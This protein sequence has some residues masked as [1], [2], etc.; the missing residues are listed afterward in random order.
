[1]EK[2]EENKSNIKLYRYFSQDIS[3]IPCFNPFRFT[4]A[5]YLN[6]KDEGSHLDF[7]SFEAL[8][9]THNSNVLLKGYNAGKRIWDNENNKRE[10]QE[11]YN[12]EIK[13]P[14]IYR[15]WNL[16]AYILSL[17]P[18]SPFT[19]N[20]VLWKRY[21][22]LKDVKDIIQKGHDRVLEYEIKIPKGCGFLILPFTFSYNTISIFDSVTY[23]SK[24][25]MS[26][27]YANINSIVPI[28]PIDAKTRLR[29]LV[30][31]GYLFKSSYWVAEREFRIVTLCPHLNIF[32]KEILTIEQKF[33]H[34]FY[35]SPLHKYCDNLY[36]K[37]RPMYRFFFDWCIQNNYYSNDITILQRDSK[38][39]KDFFKAKNYY[40][41]EN[42]KNEIH[43][44]ADEFLQDEVPEEYISMIS[45]LDKKTNTYTN[46]IMTVKQYTKEEFQKEI[47]GL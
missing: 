14:A 8:E 42:F 27:P 4:N 1:M 16:P 40:Q 33:A 12:E 23:A 32:L 2:R 37:F 28:V 19:F 30:F 38:I 9:A 39:V 31:I 45:N 15:I 20:N 24:G 6:D 21:S 26:D 35:R 29:W 10:L 22:G 36:P 34:L 5:F 43:L 11:A 7:S 13:K 25:G 46:N 18:I 41:D 17:T 47:L 44:L 3:S